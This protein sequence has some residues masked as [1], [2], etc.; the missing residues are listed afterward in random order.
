MQ[1]AKQRIDPIEQE[2]VKRHGKLPDYHYAEL[3]KQYGG[4]VADRIVQNN[5]NAI[6]A[7]MKEQQNPTFKQTE[8]NPFENKSNNQTKRR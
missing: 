7:D 5:V 8:N 2:Y 4:A 6:W 1:K 3:W